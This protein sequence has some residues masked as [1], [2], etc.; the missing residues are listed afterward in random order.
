VNFYALA[1]PSSMLHWLV[2]TSSRPW[3]VCGARRDLL[4]FCESAMTLSPPS[5]PRRRPAE[6]DPDQMLTENESPQRR[7][8]PSEKA[9][10]KRPAALAEA[11]EPAVKSEKRACTLGSKRGGGDDDDDDDHDVQMVEARAAEVRQ[12]DSAAQDAD[13]DDDVQ[14]VGRTGDLA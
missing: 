6:P 8:G 2:R 13:G 12:P 10:G 3:A 1:K 11:A 4:T 7:V 9:L 14:F 5:S